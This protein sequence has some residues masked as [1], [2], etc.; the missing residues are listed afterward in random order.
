MYTWLVG[1]CHW[2]QNLPLVVY[3]V[4]AQY[5]YPFIQWTHFTG[6][7]LWFGTTLALDFRLL[8]AG[9]RF[10]TAAELSDGLFWWNWIG[11]G[12]AVI[13]GFTLFAT[14]AVGYIANPAFRLKLGVLLPVALAWHIFVQRR[15]LTWGQTA[16]TPRVA[17]LAGGVEIALWLSVATAAV[18]IPNY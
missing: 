5:A 16:E 11:L 15:S 12:I 4:T 6:L 17:K 1:V 14:A 2:L 3:L 9:K 7:S 18:W 10:Q 13:G 8:G